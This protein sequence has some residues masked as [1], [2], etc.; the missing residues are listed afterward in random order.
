MLVLVCL[1]KLFCCCRL[2]DKV[3]MPLLLLWRVYLTVKNFGKALYLLSES[4]YVSNS[5]LQQI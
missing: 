3:Y 1:N 5:V 2:K 4:R